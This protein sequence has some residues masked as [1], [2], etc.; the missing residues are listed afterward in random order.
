ME[1]GNLLGTKYLVDNKEIIDFRKGNYEL[2]LQIRNLAIIKI[3]G[4]KIGFCALPKLIHAY[5]FTN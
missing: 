3:Y 5:S 2:R 1:F 4:F